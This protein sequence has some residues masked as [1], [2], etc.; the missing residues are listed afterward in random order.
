[1]NIICCRKKNANIVFWRFWKPLQ[2]R[3]RKKKNASTNTNSAA[4][5][6]RPNRKVVAK[7]TNHGIKTFKTSHKKC[8]R[9]RQTMPNTASKSI[10]TIQ[11]SWNRCPSE[12]LSISYLILLQKSTFFAFCDEVPFW[13]HFK[14]HC[15]QWLNFVLSLT[16]RTP[17]FW[18]DAVY[19]PRNPESDAHP[20]TCRFHIKSFYKNQ[21][22]S[23]LRPSALL[24]SF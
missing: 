15:R 23:I 22:F 5:K 21:H 9:L 7:S 13:V 24:G 12:N 16:V 18:G 2:N 3:A 14:R 11:K 4:R 17:L 1:M 20:K 19:V 8:Q 6:Y 10:Q